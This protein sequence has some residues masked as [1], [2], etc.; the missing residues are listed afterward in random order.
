MSD[1]QYAAYVL[2]GECI[3][4]A[5]AASGSRQTSYFRVAHYIWRKADLD[6]VDW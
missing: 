3:E 1:Y 5:L 2:F 6:S 4:L